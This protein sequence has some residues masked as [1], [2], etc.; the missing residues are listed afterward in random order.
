MPLVDTTCRTVAFCSSS[1]HCQLDCSYCVVNPVIKRNPSLTYDDLAFFLEA[2]GMSAFLIFSGKGDFFAGYSKRDRFLG[3]LLEH[4]VEVALDVNGLL[5][6]EYPELAETSRRKVRY[7]NL[8]M[9]YAQLRQ[10]R[11]EATWVEN[12]RT[13]LGLHQGTLNLNTILSPLERGTWEES[14]LFFEREIF[15]PTGRKLTLVADCERAFSDD[16]RAEHDRLRERFAPMVEEAY[17]ADFEGAFA[18]RGAVLCPAGKSYFRIWNDGRVEGCPWVGELG[19][20][21]NLKERTFAP[22]PGPFRCTTPRFCDCYDILQ[23]G[24]MEFEE[25]SGAAL[26]LHP[27][28]LAVVGQGGR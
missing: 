14:L 7:V 6:Q 24:R 26:P 21:G 4:D 1:G 3:R 25:P 22:R 8:T 27:G 12:A 23:L 11:A 20:L 28:P 18:G 15:G 2:V 19:G 5:L 13:L 16:E 17:H 10:K 9:H